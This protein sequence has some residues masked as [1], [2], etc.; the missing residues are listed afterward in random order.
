[1]QELKFILDLFKLCNNLSSLLAY[2]YITVINFNFFNSRMMTL[3]H[4]ESC[5]C[6]FEW[7]VVVCRQK[8]MTDMSVSVHIAVFNTITQHVHGEQG[9]KTAVVIQIN[10]ILGNL[11]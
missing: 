1:M 3:L 8:C 5:S 7:S 11:N 6:P 4:D 2:V 10:L 9:S